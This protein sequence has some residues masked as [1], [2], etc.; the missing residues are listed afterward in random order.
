MATDWLIITGKE[1]RASMSKNFL[2]AILQLLFPGF[3]AFF[4]LP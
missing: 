1:S 3:H 2:L 4:A